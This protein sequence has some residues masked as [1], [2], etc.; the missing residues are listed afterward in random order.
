MRRWLL[1]C[2]LATVVVS[3]CSSV[4]VEQ[5]PPETGSAD[6]TTPP[7]ITQPALTFGRFIS[8]PCQLV[9]RE[10]LA[11]IGIIADPG[12]A[13]TEVIGPECSWEAD[14]T[15]DTGIAVIL[16]T[17]SA[18]LDSVYMTRA[19]GYFAETRIGNYPAVN[20]DNKKPVGRTTP[21]GDCSTAVAIAKSVAF[22]VTAHAYKPNPDYE[23]P[24]RASDRVANWVLETLKAGA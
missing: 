19:E 6:S 13:T 1:C 4:G 5:A 24:C 11:T 3:G 12:K 7:E 9:S 14:K 16:M 23:E 22:R 8:D 2:A 21:F 20:T 15:T 18:G 17:N 10:Q